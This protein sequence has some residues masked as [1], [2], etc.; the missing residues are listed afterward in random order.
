MYRSFMLH[1][2]RA[3]ALATV[4]LLGLSTTAFAQD[5]E[6]TAGDIVVTAQ[7]RAQNLQDTPLAITAVNSATIEQRSMGSVVDVAA[8]APNVNI[9]PGGSAWG[10][11]AQVFIRGIGQYDSSFAFEPGVGM[12]VDDVFH[13]TM[14]GSIFDLLDLDRVEIL[15]GPQ[16]TLAGKNSIGGAVKL[17]SKKPVGDGS[18]YVE[19]GYGS[20]NR[21]ELKAS[22][23]FTLIPDQLF[24]RISGVSK[25][26]DGYMKR[27]DYG[28]M[29]P[30]SGVPAATTNANC[31]LGTEGGQDMQAGRIA[32]RWTP[33]DALEVNLVGMATEDNSEIGASK[34]LGLTT[35]A[36]MPAGTNPAQFITGPKDRTN[37]GTYVNLP[38]TDA[39]G[40]HGATYIP[41]VSKVSGREVYGSIDYELS[42]TLAIKSIS[43]YQRY[44]GSFGSDLDL[45]PYSTNS[46]NYIYDHEQ[47]T[48]ELRLSGSSLADALEWTIGGFYYKS[49]GKFGGVTFIAPG[50]TYQNFY[51]T[52]DRIPARS[53]SGFAHAAYKV[54]DAMTITAGVRYT[55]DKKTYHYGR[56]NP[57]DVTQ[58]AYTLA[59]AI[60]GIVDSFQGT[61]WDYRINVDYRWSDNV[62]TYAQFST[63]YKGGGVNPRPFAAEQ[64][65][66]FNPETLDAYEIGAKTDFFDRALRVNLSAFINKY[67]DILHIDVSPTPNSVTNATP[68]NAG[69]AEMKGV[70]LEL[71]AYP[72]DGLS[73][74]ASASWLDFKLTRIG[75]A[76]VNV[77]G[78]SRDNKAPYA[79]EW[80]LGGGIQYS[81]DIGN[82]GTITPRFDVNY[83]SYFFSNMDNN[84][85]GKVAGYTVSNARIMFEDANREWQV[86]LAVTNLF[87]KYYYLN[88]I[89]YP[90]GITVG[91]PSLPREWKVSVRRSF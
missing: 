82:A 3:A 1:S 83:Q 32:L 28:C 67:K 71:N 24:V 25:S 20:F 14:L 13:G 29:N 91:Q 89:H 55:D 38:F 21:V 35:T 2:R 5:T 88:K 26:R 57:Y 77:V 47:F 84:P 6:N 41:P 64:A 37:Y 22:A 54:T 16:G 17:Y 27:L 44:K 43:A 58:P 80:K 66:P 51:A 31:K 70:E 79:P 74:D 40:A 10:P 73:I 11:A 33:T 62:M 63:G 81:F 72:I 49:T 42:D 86:A 9:R 85:L 30:A 46:A 50:E 23:D 4:S 56:L 78:L 69:D 36:S 8:A 12:Y 76:G 7:F 68:I 15:R 48:Q 87:D 19:L 39:T 45:T 53:L 18:G 52:R 90:I 75:A 34:L 65:K 60:N 61:R 59:G